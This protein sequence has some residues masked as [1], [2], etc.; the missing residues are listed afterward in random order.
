MKTSVA[1][2]VALLSSSAM[3]QKLRFDSYPATTGIGGVRG[4]GTFSAVVNAR[5]T[6][7][8]RAGAC[9]RG[10]LEFFDGDGNVIF[11]L[12]TGAEY[13]SGCG[14]SI[15]PG[16]TPIVTGPDGPPAAN[17]KIPQVVE[18]YCGGHYNVTIKNGA[19]TCK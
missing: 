7:R 12:I 19:W 9:L 1:I 18:E 10:P 5:E 8:M 16:V 14:S 4:I 6:F 3:A 11:Q 2:A 13:P 17:V 15:I